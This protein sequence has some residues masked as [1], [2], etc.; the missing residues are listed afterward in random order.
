MENRQINQTKIYYYVFNTFGRA[1][2]GAIWCYS[3]T[4][5]K[6]KSY[7]E[8]Q[9][10][11]IPQR[12]DWWLYTFK[13]WPLRHFNYNWFI[14]SKDTMFWHWYKSDWLNDDSLWSIN[15]WYNIENI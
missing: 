13:E 10:L 15:A 11:D 3:F 6:L 4:L 9:L 2:D 7:I 5:D 14:D 1:E 12:I 8:S